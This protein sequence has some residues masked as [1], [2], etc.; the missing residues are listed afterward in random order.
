MYAGNIAIIEKSS[1]VLQKVKISGGGRCNVTHYCSDIKDFVK[2]YP[3]GSKE[4]IGAFYKFSPKDTFEWFEK[5]GVMLKTEA[6]GRVFPLSNT[7]QSIIDCLIKNTIE[8]GV[9]LHKNF[10]INNFIFENNFWKISSKN[11]TILAETLLISSGG[12]ISFMNILSQYTTHNIVN[13]VPSLFGFLCSNSVLNN[14]EGI[15]LSNVSIKISNT[16]FDSNGAIIITHSG[17]SGPAV[18]KL[19]SNAARWLYDTNY[20]F[21][22]NI[23]WTNDFNQNQIYDLLIVSKKSNPLK[24][25]QNIQIPIPV[26][27]WKNILNIYFHEIIN[28][29]ISEISDKTLNKIAGLVSNC[30]L[31]IEGKSTNKDEFVT[32]G[33][34]A[35]NEIGFKT[36]E[37]KLHKNLYFAGEILD[38]DAF[39]GGYNFQAAWTGAFIASQSILAKINS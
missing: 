9:E 37:S 39:T 32:S 6:D 26:R 12:S 4:L 38:I 16:D 30:Q 36:F 33:G 29:K 35:L 20:N 22:I 19:S 27:L 14:L 7:S 28:N 17:L 15:A 24:T 11:E 10:E 13:P 5:R 23:N 31:E 34:I 25:L 18:L 21:K 1:K 8:C 2:N 3:R